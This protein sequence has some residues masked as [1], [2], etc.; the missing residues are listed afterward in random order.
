MQHAQRV[1]SLLMAALV[2]MGGCTASGSPQQQ[3]MKLTL[4]PEGTRIVLGPNNTSDA[5]LYDTTIELPPGALGQPTEVT[6]SL[7]D[8]LAATDETAVGPALRL[9]PA[10]LPLQKPL[11]LTLP[12]DKAQVTYLDE[13]RVV[14]AGK[15]QDTPNPLRRGVVGMTAP[16]PFQVSTEM[17]GDFQSLIR[18]NDTL[19]DAGI[20][21]PNLIDKID[22]LFVID[23]SSSMAAKQKFVIEKFR[24]FINKI[25]K[26]DAKIHIGVVTTDMGIVPSG[27]GKWPHS[28]DIACDTEKG[29]D[30]ELRSQTCIDSPDRNDANCKSVCNNT[31]ING[32]AKF[33]EVDMKSATSNLP[34]GKVNAIEIADA[35]SC[36]AYQGQKGCGIEMPFASALR[37]IE[38]VNNMGFWQFN[39]DSMLPKKDQTSLQLLVFITDEDDCSVLPSN[40]MLTNPVGTVPYTAGMPTAMNFG[41]NFRCFA[42]STA[43]DQSL[44]SDGTKANCKPQM[45]SPYLYATNDLAKAISGNRK[46]LIGGIWPLMPVNGNPKEYSTVNPVNLQYMTTTKTSNM[47]DFKRHDCHIPSLPAEEGATEQHRLS[48]FADDSSFLAGYQVDICKPAEYPDVFT[49]LYDALPKATGGACK[50]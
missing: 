49:I 12:Y 27:T 22:I 21:K 38:N 6:L 50:P 48:Q 18:S 7:I 41:H 46:M 42:M 30:G 4:S 20:Y 9:T 47:I 29:D 34:S 10:N 28:N 39:P 16:V 35:F 8:T 31:K 15:H 37:A 19:P 25:I 26:C 13:L 23:N 40:R 5:R 24:S 44:T 45:G 3:I 2:A 33:I 1:R 14:V 32:G 36:I 17:L 11:Q 43:C